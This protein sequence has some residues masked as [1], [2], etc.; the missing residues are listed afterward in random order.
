LHKLGGQAPASSLMFARFSPDGCK[1]AYVRDRNIY[2]EDIA[3]HRITQLTR[4]DSPNIVNGTFDWVYEEEFHLHDGFRW[5]PDSSRI[6]FR[7]SIRLR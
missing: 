5:S 2:V 1:V 3:T 4:G 6:A 7:P